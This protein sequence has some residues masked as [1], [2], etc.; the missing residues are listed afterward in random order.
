MNDIFQILKNLYSKNSNAWI[1]DV[2][3]SVHPLIINKFLM[4]NDELIKYANYLNKF[5]FTLTVHQFLVLANKLIPKKQYRFYKYL[6]P[7]DEDDAYKDI[8]QKVR[9]VMHMSDNDWEHYKH[10]FIKEF[11]TDKVKWYR[12]LG[13]D[14]KQWKSAGLDFKDIKH[15]TE[16]PKQKTGLDMFI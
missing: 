1:L 3:N 8:L 10:Y 11:D 9:S 14:K 16:R 13:M 5:T 12:M 2:D 7:I 15:G 6:K 4:M